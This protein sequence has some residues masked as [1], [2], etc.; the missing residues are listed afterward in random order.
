MGIVST[1]E[2]VLERVLD[3]KY[4]RWG[5]AKRKRW[6]TANGQNEL[7]YDVMKIITVITSLCLKLQMIVECK[8]IIK[9]RWSYFRKNHNDISSGTFDNDFVINSWYNNDF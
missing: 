2:K 4:R 6:G 3:N 8:I 1:F 9:S 5:L 7:L